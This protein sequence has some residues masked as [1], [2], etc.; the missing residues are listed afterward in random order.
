M[1]RMTKHLRNRRPAVRTPLSDRIYKLLDGR[2]Q[3]WLTKRSGV[4]K[5]KVV[6]VLR[7][8]A[9]DF[10]AGEALLVAKAFGI[11]VEDMYL[12]V[13]L[14][15]LCDDEEMDETVSIPPR[16]VLDVVITEGLVKADTKA[17]GKTDNGKH[18]AKPKNAPRRKGG[19]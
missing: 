1:G 3:P 10:Y 13:K 5:S 15:Y 4:R 19:V 9:K 14:D 8:T 7:G 2:K 18:R 11:S 6:D 17:Q 16:S 12:D